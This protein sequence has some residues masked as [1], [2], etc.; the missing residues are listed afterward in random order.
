MG[1]VVWDVGLLES[2]RTT[3]IFDRRP[4]IEVIS[5]CD[6]SRRLN[7]TRRKRTEGRARSKGTRQPERRLPTCRQTASRWRSAAN[8]ALVVI[9]L[10]YAVVSFFQLQA[11]R[12]ANSLT[13]RALEQT[14]R[15]VDF[16]AQA[17]QLAQKNMDFTLRVTG[18]T[19]RAWV[20]V[21]SIKKPNLDSN[22]RVEVTLRNF[23]HSP[24][25]NILTTCFT[26][27]TDEAI[28][29]AFPLP[30]H[31]VPIPSVAIIGP[32]SSYAGACETERRLSSDQVEAIM[33]GK[34]TFYVYGVT[35]YRD[36]FNADLESGFCGYYVRRFDQFVHCP[37]HQWMR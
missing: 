32:G 21:A 1:Y 8:W 10:S 35:M 11:L 13:E 27:L 3:W 15:S 22:R 29:R 34:V 16:A 14:R 23:G 5:S 6:Q 18:M 25:F 33:A 30:P 17:N 31:R 4:F 24:A 2:A 28:S 36:P 26:N 20:S 37:G 19:Q 9:T 12:H 7:G